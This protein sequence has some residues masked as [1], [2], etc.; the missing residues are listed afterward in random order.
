M[1]AVNRIVK[2][3]FCELTSRRSANRSL[4]SVR[5]LRSFC[6][7]ADLSLGASSPKSLDYLSVVKRA[8]STII[9][10]SN[11][12]QV[13]LANSV[14]VKLRLTG[15][16]SDRTKTDDKSEFQHRIRSYRVAVD[17]AEGNHA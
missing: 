10:L 15:R 2:T 12:V 8:P 16:G 1:W 13:A 17:Q 9:E 3:K 14:R 6:K 7:I 4:V 5:L 11:S